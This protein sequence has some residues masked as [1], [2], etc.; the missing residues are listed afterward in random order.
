MNQHTPKDI[1]AAAQ[2]HPT[3]SSRFIPMGE[4]TL[5]TFTALTQ[6]PA[7]S[8]CPNPAS[9]RVHS[10]TGVR[11]IAPIPTAARRLG[12]VSSNPQYPQILKP[13]SYTHLRAHETP[14]H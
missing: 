3:K 4:R 6:Q 5:Q 1:N 14:E 2:V 12:N 13:V 9:I 7:A 8:A 11:V 10:V